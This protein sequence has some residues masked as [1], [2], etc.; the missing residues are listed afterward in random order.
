MEIGRKHPLRIIHK[1]PCQGTFNGISSNINETI[2]TRVDE[3]V[4]GGRPNK[5]YL[6]VPLYLDIYRMY[7]IDCFAMFRNVAD[8]QPLSRTSLSSVYI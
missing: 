3:W 5:I 6:S 4:G 7:P 2:T 8:Q 1:F